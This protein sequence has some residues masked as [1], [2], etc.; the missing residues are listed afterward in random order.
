MNEYGVRTVN[1][2]SLPAQR[3]LLMSEMSRSENIPC[4]PCVVMC[5]IELSHDPLSSGYMYDS[6]PPGQAMM[7]HDRLRELHPSQGLISDDLRMQ[8]QQLRVEAFAYALTMV[9]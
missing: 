8:L 1:A 6:V 7:E 5:L 4:C 3:C 2:P 9:C